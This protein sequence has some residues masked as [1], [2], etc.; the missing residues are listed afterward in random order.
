MRTAGRPALW[1]LCRCAPRRPRIDRGI[2]ALVTRAR[3]GSR[4]RESEVT[5][6]FKAR[7]GDV[8]ADLF[9]GRRTARPDQRRRRVR[10]V[11]N[12]NINYTNVCSYQCSFCAF[13]KGKTHEQ[14]RGK[15]YDL[16]LDEVGAARPRSVGSGRDRGLHA[17]RHPSALHRRHLSGLLRAV[18]DECRACMSTPSRRWKSRTGAATLGIPVRRYLEMLRDAGLGSL[19]GTA[20]EILDDEVRARDLPGQAQHPGVARRGRHRPRSRACAPPRPSCSAMS[21]TP[22]SWARHLLQLRDLQERT[23]GIT[24]FVPLPFVHMEAPISYAA[25][26]A[27]ARPGARRV[28][29]HAVVAAGAASADHQHPGVLGQARR[30]GRRRV[31]CSGGVNDLGGTLMNESISR[32]AGTQHGQELA[33]EQMEGVI[34]SLGRRSSS[35]PRC[36][37]RLRR[38]AARPASARQPLPIW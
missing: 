1:S 7:G 5:A 13:S 23:G 19:P 16:A 9:S 22:S 30:T 18:K 27:S 2:D 25:S 36:T 17:G 31:A 33:P 8:D 6:L 35:A 24:E 4:L 10:Y 21:S 34:R 14:L 32:A 20:A 38:S 26:R 11:V 29:M 15:P 28:L 37:S 3:A 12:R